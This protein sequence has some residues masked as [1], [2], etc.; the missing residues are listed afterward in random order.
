MGFKC[1]TTN[2][3]RLQTPRRYLI[4]AYR[5]RSQLS[6]KNRTLRI[7]FQQK[8]MHHMQ[9]GR[10]QT[11]APEMALLPKE[12]LVASTAVGKVE[13]NSVSHFVVKNMEHD[14]VA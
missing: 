11:I 2:I 10:P 13:A 1:K 14:G 4:P 9:I 3:T 5:A 12:R 8:Q 7:F 6:I